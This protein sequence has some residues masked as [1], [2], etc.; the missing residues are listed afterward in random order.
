MGCSE[1]TLS[2]QLLGDCDTLITGSACYDY[3]VSQ[4][5]LTMI[6]RV[7]AE[8]SKLFTA[9]VFVFAV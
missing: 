3:A 5:H 4:C 2:I 7:T 1:Q 9:P 6:L 8:Q